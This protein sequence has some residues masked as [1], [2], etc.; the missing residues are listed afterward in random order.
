LDNP[1]DWEEE[2][3]WEKVDNS[4]PIVGQMSFF[5]PDNSSFLKKK[6]NK[7]NFSSSFE[8]IIFQNP[9]YTIGELEELSWLA[10]TMDVEDDCA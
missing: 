8:D 4:R 3:E 6:V 1:C 9:A 7:D 2:W 5:P 10:E